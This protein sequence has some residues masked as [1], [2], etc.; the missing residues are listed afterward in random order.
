MSLPPKPISAADAESLHAEARR[1]H[2]EVEKLRLEV[3][4]LRRWRAK[5]VIAVVSAFLAPLITIGTFVLASSAS[6]WAE[7][8]RD[9]DALYGKVVQDF[10]STSLPRRLSA[11]SA[12]EAF[13]A[14]QQEEWW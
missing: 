12:M 6:R 13:T 9:A 10:A 5:A 11:I 1:L 14:Q 4:D 2:L 8:K 3:A 7:R